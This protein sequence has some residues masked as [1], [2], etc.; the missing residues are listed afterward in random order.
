MAKVTVYKVRFYDMQ[1][2]EFQLSR[3]MATR[4][5]ADRMRAEIIEDT[6]TEIDSSQLEEGYEWTPRDF[7][8]HARVGFQTKIA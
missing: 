7:N 1:S 8:P 2:D 5:G 3:R 4:S 6:A